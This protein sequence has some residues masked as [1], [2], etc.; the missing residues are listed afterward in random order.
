M[1]NRLRFALG[2]LASIDYQRRFIVR[3]TK[4]GFILPDEL[5]DSATNAAEVTL[6]QPI[7][8]QA[9]DST[10]LAA[11]RYF[12][13]VAREAARTIP[14]DLPSEDLIENNSGWNTI[15]TAAQTCLDALG[16]KV[17]LKELVSRALVSG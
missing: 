7:L 2:S 14:Y 5:L 15:R 6:A 10:E 8:S 9:Y 17:S 13:Q 4:D 12:L 3:A 1:R 16:L 11:I